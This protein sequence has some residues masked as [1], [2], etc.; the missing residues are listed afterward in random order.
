MKLIFLIVWVWLGFQGFAC[1]DW[2]LL[3][4]NEPW[5]NVNGG[6]FAAGSDELVDGVAC[7]T[8]NDELS[9]NGSR[10]GI[11]HGVFESGGHSLTV[12]DSRVLDNIAEYAAP[13]AGDVLRWSFA[14]KAEFTCTATASMHLVFGSHIRTV[15]SQKALPFNNDPYA[16]FSGTYEITAEDAEAGMPFVRLEL[17]S[18]YS[19]TVFADDVNLQVLDPAT[20][21]PENL[22]AET[23]DSGIELSWSDS[24]EQNV[25]RKKVGDSSFEQIASQLQGSSFEDT[26]IIC[27]VEYL[28]LVTTIRSGTE[29]SASATEAVRKVDA[30]A[31]EP[32]V[33]VTA[34]G[35]EV[36]TKLCWSVVD[37]DIHHVV[38]YRGNAD[39]SEMQVL[40]NPV[41]DSEFIDLA[42][43]KGVENGYQIQAVDFSGNEGALSELVTAKVLAVKGA[44]FNDL[45]LPVPAGAGLRSDLWGDDAVLPRNAENG[46]EDTAWS[47]WG[48]R[49][50]AGSDGKFHLCVTRWPED[51]RKGHWD[52]PQSTIAYAVSD[53]PAGPYE[54]VRD[55]AYD[56]S[57]GL[58]HNADIV[59]LKDGR[60]LLYALID[61]QPT[62]FSSDSMAGPWVREGVM[63]V[64]YDSVELGDDRDYQVQRNL[65]GVQLDDG[66]MLWVTKFGRMIKS[67]NGILGP[68]SVLTDVVQHNETIPEE[69]R[70][71]NYEDPVM[72]RDDVQFHLII[73][74]FYD[75]RAVYL[76]SPDGINWTCETGFAYTPDCTFYADGTRTRWHKL[77]RPHV[78]TDEYGRATHL[79]LAGIDVAKELDF[80]A[81]NHS[82]KNLIMP[83][84]VHKRLSLLNSQ[85]VDS[86]TEEIRLL[87]HSEEG[88]DAQQ[89]LDLDSLHFGAAEEVNFGRGAVL[90]STESHTDGLILIFDGAGNGLTA[91]NFAGKLIGQTTD[92]ALVTGYSKLEPDSGLMVEAG[93]NQT[94]LYPE[95]S[96]VLAGAASDENGTVVSAVWRQVSGPE[97]ALLS[98]ADSLSLTASNLIKGTYTFSLTAVDDDE[99]SASDIVTV[100]VEKDPSQIDRV[101]LWGD[102]FDAVPLDT[103]SVNNQMIGDTEVVTANTLSSRVVAAPAAFVGASGHVLVLSRLENKYAA[104]CSA[105]AIDLSSFALSSGDRY[106]ISFD[107]YIPGELSHAVGGVNFRWKDGDHTDNGPTDRSYETLAPGVH[108]LQYEGTFPV[109]TG[110]GD[111]F[112]DSLQPFIWFNPGG[113]ALDEFAYV[114]N[115]S[116]KIEPPPIGHTVFWEENF[117][118][119]TI[120][121]TSQ[122]VGG[123]KMANTLTGVIATVPPG[124]AAADGGVLLLSSGENA[125]ASLIPSETVDLTD[126]DIQPGDTYQLSFDLYLPADLPVAVG[127]VNF[128]WKNADNTANGPTDASRAVS[129][130]G[131]HRLVYTGKF[132]VNTGGEDFIPTSVIPFVWFDQDGAVATDHA[133]IDNIYFEISPAE[134]SPFERFRQRL[135]LAGGADAD[136]DLDGQSNYAEFVTGTCPTNAMSQFQINALQAERSGFR[137]QLDSIIGRRYTIKKTDD[138]RSDW[139]VYTN[140][141]LGTGSSIEMIDPDIESNRFYRISVEMAE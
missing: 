32:P 130:A 43:I 127:G 11:E 112:P 5:G 60:Y 124:F 85:P 44:A 8:V 134:M 140:G 3:G 115:I 12:V 49:P 20:A 1:A 28:Y 77:E 63:K 76:R 135:S 29:S 2:T 75:Y 103:V 139:S 72:W 16:V 80:G 7:W 53:Q 64:E 101:V 50:V 83:L 61:W 93:S 42:P 137:I 120:G 9:Q 84:V 71:S 74:A 95:S 100:V 106:S 132:P 90:K 96:I 30:V 33:A 10:A 129:S 73:N 82:S 56:F 133:Y 17:A 70:N 99:H 68:Y 117:N 18:D 24:G 36:V 45:I 131:Q 19:I 125:Y 122:I 94:I 67:E 108:H 46:I 4:N 25:Y 138:L 55:L 47:Y 57:D 38:I 110:T 114:D 48:G 54:I 81:D 97:T 107:L 88:F 14:A 113:T 22:M 79:S 52:W 126:V 51:G 69:Y 87:I 98:G 136:D 58:G 62:L 91:E 102:D 141:I 13:V 23:T 92:G 39:G 104:L 89:D 121:N 65:S 128:R 21:G 26:S 111:F 27:G 66:S 6:D 123:A 35:L 86:A 40:E 59:L 41:F 15:A 34:E 119:S 116:F 37:S 109:D 105:E 78:L 31:P 118:D